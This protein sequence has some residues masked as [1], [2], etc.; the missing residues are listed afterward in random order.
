MIL[1]RLH[2]RHQIL[3]VEL[4]HALDDGLHQLARRCVVGVL[5]DG[6]DADALA[7]EQGFEGDCML[8]LACEAGE[9]PDQNFLEGGVGNQR[10]WDSF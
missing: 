7:P 1:S 8:A 4:V 2:H 6:D 3:A 10:K 5:G 9:L